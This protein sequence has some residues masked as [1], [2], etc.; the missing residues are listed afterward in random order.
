MKEKRQARSRKGGQPG[1]SR[2][3]GEKGAKTRITER[4]RKEVWK[5]K[6]GHIILQKNV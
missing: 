5:R 2:E 1:V 6:V 3:R 4:E